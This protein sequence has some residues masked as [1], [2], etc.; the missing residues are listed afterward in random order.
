VPYIEGNKLKFNIL[1][2]QAVCLADPRKSFL[3]ISWLAS[4][5][6]TVGWCVA[7]VLTTFV[8]EM[9]VLFSGP[10]LRVIFF[11]SGR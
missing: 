2:L 7:T 3:L 10:L 9:Q 5:Q 1:S 11:L 6:Q 4:K 8:A